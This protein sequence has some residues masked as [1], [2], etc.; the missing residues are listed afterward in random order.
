MAI[1]LK[2]MGWL[3]SGFLR[4]GLRLIPKIGLGNLFGMLEYAYRLKSFQ[5]LDDLWVPIARRFL[6]SSGEHSRQ[7]GIGWRSQRLLPRLLDQRRTITL[8]LRA[9]GCCSVD[10]MP[11]DIRL[12][13]HFQEHTADIEENQVAWPEHRI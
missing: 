1:N 3:H 4:F 9:V 5:F 7:T 10:R 8:Y 12:S 2:R 6:R 11:W 13:C